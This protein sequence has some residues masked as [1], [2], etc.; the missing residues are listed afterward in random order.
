MQKPSY[1][2]FHLALFYQE[3]RARLGIPLN[4]LQVRQ[5]LMDDRALA[6][7][8]RSWTPNFDPMRQMT[9]LPVTAR[10]RRMNAVTG[11]I[12][13]LFLCLAAIF[14]GVAAAGAQ[15]AFGH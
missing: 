1:E 15:R 3:D 10:E 9:R 4:H 2:E 12:T 11:L 13:V 5:L 8:Y 7:F 6:T 14:I